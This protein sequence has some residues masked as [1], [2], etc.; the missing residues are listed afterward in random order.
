MKVALPVLCGLVVAAWLIWKDF[1][2]EAIRS[3]RFTTTAVIGILVAWL[4]MLG[5]DFGYAWR[6]RVLTDGDLSWGKAARVTMLME[7]T[8]AITP[9]T[10]GGS[11]MSAVFMHRNGI[12]SGRATTLMITTLFLDELFFTFACPLILAIVPYG[13]LFGFSFGKFDSGL[14]VVFWCV[15]GGVVAVTVLLFCGIILWPTSVSG[16]IKR[17]FRWRILRRWQAS[18]CAL[19][20]DMIVT[21]HQLRH[22]GSGWWAKAFGATALSWCSRFFVVNALFWGFVPG[23]D[24]LIVLG[25]QMVVWMVLMISPTPG[26]SGVSEWLF[27]T[28]YGDLITGG[29]AVAVVLAMFWRIISYYIYLAVGVFLLPSFFKHKDT[30]K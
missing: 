12:S 7:F 21:S 5:R 20:D 6:F 15:Y 2:P 30:D 16:C 27:T 19:A 1:D 18:A 22:Y 25:R 9:T 13:D 23:A 29:A 26:G 8:S 3:L 4:F 10:V 14:R 28:Y 24:Q 17:L 11:A